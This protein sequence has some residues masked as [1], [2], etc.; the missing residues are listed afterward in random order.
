MAT[1]KIRWAVIEL[2]NVMSLFDVQRV[3]RSTDGVDGTYVE[4]TTPATRVPLVAG[5]T[6]YLYDDTTGDPAYYYKIDYY[7]SVTTNASDKSDP[8]RGGL[9]GYIDVQDIRD[10]GFTETAIADQDV[11]RGIEMATA[12]I[13]RATMQWFEPRT[14]T[15]KLDQKRQYDEL[16]LDI[17]IIAITKLEVNG[18]EED[19]TSF[20][21]YNRHLTQGLLSPDD[22]AHPHLKV[23][24]LDPTE[25]LY[26]LFGR[27]FLRGQQ[28]T[29]VE[30]VFGYTELGPNDPIGETEEGSQIP[31]AYG[32]TP[33]LI[34][35]AAK[36]LTIRYMWPIGSGKGDDFANRGRIKKEQ[37]E[38]QMY[39]M[40][41]VSGSSMAPGAS[42]A[43]GD[44]EVDAILS[45]FM[46]PARFG[47]V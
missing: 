29:T 9:S 19:L 42:G 4:I 17:P 13:D 8:I 43:T 11:I 1:I 25:R 5:V 32:S 26:P 44:P 21:V 35:H 24:E 33:K 40:Q 45:S 14:R 6:N 31:L 47:G 20:A 38:D 27:P 18:T 41:A 7:N 3:Y 34:Q 39:E 36:L 16:H 30:G 10:E 12:M 46:G 28:I 15:F 2:T 37:T 23:K 22:R